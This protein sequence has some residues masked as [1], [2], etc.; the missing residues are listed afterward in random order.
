M[1]TKNSDFLMIIG[2]FFILWA[3]V[4][5]VTGYWPSLQEFGVSER[6]FR[7]MTIVAYGMGSV[8]LGIGFLSRQHP[9]N[10]G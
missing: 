3:V 9:S 2:V 8:A 1:N 7:F 4:L 10:E 6:F 5:T